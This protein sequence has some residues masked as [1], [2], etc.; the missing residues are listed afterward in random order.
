ML[1][2]CFYS[3]TTNDKI[4]RDALK[5][6]LKKLHSDDPK[7]IIVEEL[8]I[9]HGAARVDIAVINGT[10]HGYEIKSDQDTLLRLPNQMDIYNAVFGQI[11]LVVGKSHLYDAI[12][13]IPDWWGITIAKIDVDESIIFQSIREPTNNKQQDNI[14]IARLLWRSEALDILEKAGQSQGFRSKPRG[15]IYEK[16]STVFDQ[17]V[18]ERE[19]REALFSRKD[20]RSGQLPTLN[21]G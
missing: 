4:I 11:T 2:Y 18:L 1:P 6:S 14:S 10:L 5:E 9:M 13:I 19:V 8:G 3:M 21:G 7:L 16:L 20:W 17:Q 12:N 15:A